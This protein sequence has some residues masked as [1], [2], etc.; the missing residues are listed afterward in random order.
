MGR[1]GHFVPN[2]PCGVESCSAKQYSINERPVPNAPCGVESYLEFFRELILM[3]VF[4]MHRVELK[5][6]SLGSLAVWIAGQVPN[7]PCGVERKA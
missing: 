3:L 2:A 1:I 5:V 6:S 4:L 7:A